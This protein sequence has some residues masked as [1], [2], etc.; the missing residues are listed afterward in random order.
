MTF[1]RIRRIDDST[2]DGGPS[3]RR[4]EGGSDS[5]K[6]SRSFWV[7][8]PIDKVLHKEVMGTGIGVSIH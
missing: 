8:C 2:M 5:F 3:R 6:L 7:E 1:L 4:E